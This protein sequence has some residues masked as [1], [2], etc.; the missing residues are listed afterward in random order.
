MDKNRQGAPVLNDP[1]PNPVTKE[2]NLKE[3]TTKFSTESGIDK[4][5]VARLVSVKL[6]YHTHKQILE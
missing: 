5:K 4:L 1:G 6:I 2:K 3:F